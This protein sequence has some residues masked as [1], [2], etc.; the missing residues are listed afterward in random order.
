MSDLYSILEWRGLIYDATRDTEQ[1][2]QREKAP[3]GYAGFDPTARSLHI[4]SLVPI[5]G[6]VHLQRTG[7]RP[8][9]VVGGGT[10]MVGDPSGRT[11]ERKFLTREELDANVEGLRAQ[12]SH[13]LD[14]SGTHAAQMVN[15]LDWLGQITLLDFLREIGKYYTVNQMLAKESV[16]LRLDRA[17]EGSEGISY[18]EFSYMLMQAYD[19]LHLFDTRSCRF[20]IGG[21]DQW[22][23]ITAGIELIG[24]LRQEQAYGLVMPLV[25]MSSGQKFGKSESGNVWLDAELTSPYRFYQY[26]INIP[27]ADVVRYL[28]YFTL[29]SR[30][31]IVDIER[32]HAE[33]PDRRIAQR[34]LADDLT[35]RVHGEDGLSRA[36]TASKALFGGDLEALSSA[37]LADV[38]SDVPSVN[39]ATLEEAREPFTAVELCVWSGMA[40]SKGEAR[41]LIEGG[42]VYVNNARV[43]DHARPVEKSARLHGRY[44]VLRRGNRSYYLIEWDE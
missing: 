29:L 10:G 3:V 44:L 14:F 28:K 38:F 23:N 4:G 18:T 8:I 32:E 12:L 1:F 40:R 17:R 24:R 27:D 7:G 9:A 16:R 21:S 22:G 30:E 31:R 2:L 25:T 43:E 26:W 6:L 39:L 35:R 20:Q 13:F 33:A 15:N 37:D 19:F 41:R 5:M 42:G 11:S 36:V 34:A